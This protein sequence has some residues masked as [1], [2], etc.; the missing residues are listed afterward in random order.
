[1]WLDL[2]ISYNCVQPPYVTRRLQFVIFICFLL[3]MPAIKT[4]S[5][6]LKILPQKACLQAL[7]S[8]SKFILAEFPPAAH[9][10]PDFLLRPPPWPPPG[11]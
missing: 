5:L 7:Y 1:M 4:G 10:S 11:K 2:N 9:S 6:R 8:F 3:A